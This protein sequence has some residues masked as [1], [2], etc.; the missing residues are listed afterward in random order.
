MD[1]ESTDTQSSG[2]TKPSLRARS[3]QLT[4]NEVS[5]Y[6]T[7]RS[8]FESLTTCDYFISCREI[9]PTTGHEH[10][11]IYAHF[12][13]PRN[14]SIKKCCGSHIEIC[15]GSPQQNIAYI[16][17]DGNI[18]D[19][20]GTEPHQGFHKVGDLKKIDNPD[21]LNWNEYNTW[22]KIKN[23]PKKIKV[24]DWHKD[25]AVT[26]IYGKSG[27]GKSQYAKTL[28]EMEN[29]EEFEE[30]KFVNNFWNGIVDGTGACIYDD[31]RDN[32]MKP[33]EFINFIDYN[34]HNLN[35]KGGNCR[36]QYNRIII[37]SIQ[38][39]KKIYRNIPEEA[40]K[41]WLRRMKISKLKPNDELVYDKDWN[42]DN[43]D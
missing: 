24:K 27:T 31:F 32:H 19:E 18:I 39:P 41:Q 5:N 21:D 9:A 42:E 20:W 43:D 10:I 4:L 16:R 17:K 11:H 29:I 30:V 13:Q 25:I 40:R 35:V 23:A 6:E 36:N 12:N 22:L 34:V 28:L 26:W 3:F 14:L 33:A 2:N 1:T 15:K 37:T 7:V 38:N 8:Y